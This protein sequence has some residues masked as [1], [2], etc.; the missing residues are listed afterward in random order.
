M[1][2]ISVSGWFLNYLAFVREIDTNYEG[3]GIKEVSHKGKNSC[4]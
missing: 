2:F 4:K 1:V 3:I